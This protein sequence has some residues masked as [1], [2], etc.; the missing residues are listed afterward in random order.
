MRPT[1]NGSGA[2]YHVSKNNFI[3]H[4]TNPDLWIGLM[5]GGGSGVPSVMTPVVINHEAETFWLNFKNKGWCEYPW[6]TEFTSFNTNE[7]CQQSKQHGKTN[8]PVIGNFVGEESSSWP[9]AFDDFS[10]VTGKLLVLRTRNEARACGESVSCMLERAFICPPHLQDLTARTRYADRTRFGEGVVIGGRRYAVQ[11][12]SLTNWSTANPNQT[13]IWTGGEKTILDGNQPEHFKI[14]PTDNPYW[15][16]S[17][18]SSLVQLNTGPIYLHVQVKRSWCEPADSG[19]AA[20][21]R[22]PLPRSG[23]SFVWFR[24]E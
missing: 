2:L 13:F 18:G 1:A 6:G 16:S 8:T 22:F 12:A 3:E 4:P 5:N 10:K 17:A 11:E 19:D 24:L 7:T 15:G 20:W 21:D 23:G 14:S 9:T